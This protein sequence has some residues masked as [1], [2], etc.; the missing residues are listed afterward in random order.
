MK[1]KKRTKPRKVFAWYWY[2]I[3]ASS[4]WGMGDEPLPVCVTVGFV[5]AKPSKKNEMPF[6]RVMG[7]WVEEEPGGE[8]KIP[9][10]M[11]QRRVLLGTV[12]VPWR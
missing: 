10:A 11:L 5:G 3:E 8:T 12:L 1:P 9:V 4:A 6:W 2:D 7:S